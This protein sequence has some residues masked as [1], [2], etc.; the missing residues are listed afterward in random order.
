MKCFHN[1]F[2]TSAAAE[3]GIYMRAIK[4][5]PIIFLLS[6]SG[7]F[8]QGQQSSSATTPPPN[9]SQATQPAPV[10]ATAS[11]PAKVSCERGHETRILQIETKGSGCSLD[12]TKSNKLTAVTSAPHGLKHCLET[13][14]RIKA[15]L[16]KAGFKCA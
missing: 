1:E 14:K 15:K 11:G 6:L 8:G 10:A 4:I 2:L 13:Q 9:E 16:E 5:F 12:Y 3:K 7:C